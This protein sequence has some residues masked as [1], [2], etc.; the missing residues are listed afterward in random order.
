MEVQLNPKTLVTIPRT[1]QEIDKKISIRIAWTSHVWK[2]NPC[3]IHQIENFEQ[4][5]LGRKNDRLKQIVGFNNMKHMPH[6][7]FNVTAHDWLFW[8]HFLSKRIYSNTVEVRSSSVGK[9]YPVTNLNLG[10]QVP[11]D[12]GQG[13]AFPLC[14]LRWMLALIRRV[15]KCHPIVT[16][17]WQDMS[18]PGHVTLTLMDRPWPWIP[19][20]KVTLRSIEWLRELFDK[21]DNFCTAHAAKVFRL[22]IQ[23][24]V[25]LSA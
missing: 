16:V 6:S 19:R 8:T 24:H 14:R 22:H 5:R 12:V 2:L 17:W 23:S 21:W 3:Q 18:S 25:L 13:R 1:W 4:T 15:K 11:K 9:W 7:S 10:R 20:P